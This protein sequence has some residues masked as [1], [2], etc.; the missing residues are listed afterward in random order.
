VTGNITGTLATAAQPNITSVGT[1]T[2]FTSTGIDDNA[3][4]TAITIDS[5][6]NVALTGGLTLAN[7]QYLSSTDA[8]SNAPRMFGINA[9][10]TTYI[11]PID[12]YAGGD[13]YYGVSANVANQAFYTAGSQ[14]ASA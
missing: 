4:A 3:D 6:E 10:N 1:L 9:A 5:S 8:S 2:G 11:G 7:S 14:N 12:A 13:V